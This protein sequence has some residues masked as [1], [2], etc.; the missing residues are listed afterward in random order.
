M[1]VRPP[2]SRPTGRLFPFQG[3][4]GGWNTLIQSAFSATPTLNLT[5]QAVMLNVAGEAKLLISFGAN[6]VQTPMLMSD[7]IVACHAK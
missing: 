7:D 3:T 5:S 2:K 6:S 4:P 1:V